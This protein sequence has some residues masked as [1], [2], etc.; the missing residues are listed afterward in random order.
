MLQHSGLVFAHGLG[1]GD[2]LP[3]PV[4]YAVVGGAW[5]LV[6]SFVVLA[7]AWRDPRFRGDE[8]GVALPSWVTT[9]VDSPWTRAVVRLLAAAFTAYFLVALVFGQDLLTNPV[10]GIF[11]VWLWVGLIPLSL[12]FGPIWTLISPVRIVHLTLSRL[13]GTDPARG[14]RRYP[15]RLGYWPAALGLTAF[16][17]FELVYPDNTLLT[18]LRLWIGCYAAIMLIGGALLGS[19]W[20]ERADPFEVLSSLIAR[21]SPFGRRT[22]GRVVVRNPLENLDG[23]VPDRGLMAVV[24]VLLGSTAA[25]SFLSGPFWVSTVP[26]LPVDAVLLDTLAL[27]A[28]IVFVAGSLSVASLL[29]GRLG[30]VDA[31]PLPQQFAPSMVPII[32]GYFVAHYVTYLLET[33]QQTL[34]QLSDPL[35]TGADLLGTADLGINFF[36]TTNVTLL[37]VIK[38]GAIVIGHLLAAVAA[39]D[40]AVRILSP[41]RALIGQLP[42]LLVMIVYTVGGLSLL[43]SG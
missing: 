32:V 12:L 42:L 35:S 27:F 9:A 41:R 4:G 16:V 7:F 8:S 23:L 31:R 28:F 10:F 21:V 30:G 18:P 39:H 15:A 22:D 26:T 29:A 37:F 25:D 43:L 1:A 13:A 33:G 24:A 14:L 19:R 2:D 38:V 36:L 5:A 11:Y 34:A 20:F 17:W 40:R 3:I 6:I